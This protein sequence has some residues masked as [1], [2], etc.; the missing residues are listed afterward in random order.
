MTGHFDR[1]ERQDG[2]SN[3]SPGWPYHEAKDEYVSRAEPVQD[4]TDEL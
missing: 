1:T 4:A 3:T 2:V